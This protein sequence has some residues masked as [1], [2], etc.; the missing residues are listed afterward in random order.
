MQTGIAD[1]ARR[2]VVSEK[3]HELEI[4]SHTRD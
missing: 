2:C 4:Q 3:D 1:I